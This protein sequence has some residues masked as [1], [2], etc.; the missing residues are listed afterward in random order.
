M[1]LGLHHYRLK[2]VAVVI[3]GNLIL[4]DVVI[5]DYRARLDLIQSDRD[6]HL[7][8]LDL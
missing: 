3:S 8:I 5:T 2:L 1:V 7:H 4:L 6:L